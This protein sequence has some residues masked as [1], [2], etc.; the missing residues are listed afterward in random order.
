MSLHVINW[1]ISFL[2]NRKQRAFADGVLTKLVDINRGVPKG[3]VFLSCLVFFFF[4]FFSVSDFTVLHPNK[5]LLLK[6]ADDTTLSVPI[7]YLVEVQNILRW[8][9]ENRITL[10]LKT[11]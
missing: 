5:N 1:I 4:F 8:S 11:T 3:T 9:I 10:N 6:Y 7:R 2:S